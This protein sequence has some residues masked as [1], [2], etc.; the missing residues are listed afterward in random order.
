MVGGRLPA[1]LGVVAVGCLWGCRTD[2]RP[3]GMVR[4]SLSV[5]TRLPASW[6]GRSVQGEGTLVWLMRAE[7]CLSCES[8]D[9][10]LRQAQRRFGLPVVVVVVGR[11][12]SRTEDLAMVEAY[13]RQRRLKAA[14]VPVDVE[15]YQRRFASGTLPSVLLVANGRVVW[16]SLKGGSAAEVEW[17]LNELKQRFIHRDADARAGSMAGT[18]PQRR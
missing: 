5:G 6:I 8:P 15:D 1:A 17:V 3:A 13:I 18:G 11:K 12:A 9:Y 16:R 10:L 4:D 14:V 2:L 7:D